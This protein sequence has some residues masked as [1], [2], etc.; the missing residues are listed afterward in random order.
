MIKAV[1]WRI[2]PSGHFVIYALTGAGR[3]LIRVDQ[4]LPN[5]EWITL[6]DWFEAAQVWRRSPEE[7]VEA[8]RKRGGRGGMVVNDRPL[9]EAARAV[10]E[11][12]KGL[13]EFAYAAWRRGEQR[14]GKPAEDAGELVKAFLTDSIV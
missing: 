14:Y 5:G 12:R 9:S 10:L 6:S 11:A 4:P 1:A 8:N 2:A 7:W 3:I 13:H